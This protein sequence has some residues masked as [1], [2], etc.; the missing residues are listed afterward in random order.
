MWRKI[1]KFALTSLN[2]PLFS[3]DNLG[4]NYQTCL[5]YFIFDYCSQELAT[6]VFEGN[7][8]VKLQPL[9]GIFT[10]NKT[11]PI[12]QTEHKKIGDKNIIKPDY[13]VLV[14]LFFFL[15]FL[16][17]WLLIILC[18]KTML[19]I[20]NSWKETGCQENWC[21]TGLSPGVKK[22]WMRLLT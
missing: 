14:R 5:N 4:D 7:N 3:L 1:I 15:S 21:Q 9:W 16:R 13:P 12:K 18:M 20:T 22:Q 8:N 2:L 17:K 10:T 11:C 19:D 6:N